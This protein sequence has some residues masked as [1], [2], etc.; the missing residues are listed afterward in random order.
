MT[1]YLYRTPNMDILREN[2]DCAKKQWL[3]GI[4]DYIADEIMLHI[5]QSGSTI[6]YYP[7]IDTSLIF[8]MPHQKNKEF[9]SM[10]HEQLEGITSRAIRKCKLFPDSEDF[11][12]T[13]V[14]TM[15]WRRAIL[16]KTDTLMIELMIYHSEDI[17]VPE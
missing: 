17:P 2:I 7:I 11:K 3:E 15:H 5:D 8:K 6:K 12:D 4:Y 1:R 10:V 16:K 13:I 9:E 14:N